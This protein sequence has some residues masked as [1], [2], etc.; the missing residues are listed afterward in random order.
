MWVVA[1]GVCV[2]RVCVFICT[3]VRRLTGERA[4]ALA[5][6]LISPDMDRRLAS[7][8][9]LLIRLKALCGG[10][11]GGAH[12]LEHLWRSED[13]LQESVFSF[14]PVVPGVLDICGL[15][16]I[17]PM[18]LRTPVCVCLSLCKRSDTP[19]L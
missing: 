1:I 15:E 13:N 11:V 2:C 12:V 14:Y 10:G 19:T 4:G 3:C 9:S 5:A 6:G 8:S 7:F 16:L 17:R 18:E